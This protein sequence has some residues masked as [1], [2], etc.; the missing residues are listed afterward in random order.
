MEERS[1]D[2]RPP[3]ALMREQAGRVPTAVLADLQNLRGQAASSH[4]PGCRCTLPYVRA[5]AAPPESLRFTLAALI[6]YVG[7]GL[8]SAPRRRRPANCIR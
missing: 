7:Q 2:L 4:P 3:A 1:S 5:N 8:P 6:S